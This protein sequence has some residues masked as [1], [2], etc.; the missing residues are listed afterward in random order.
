MASPWTVA[1]P[2]EWGALRRAHDTVIGD[3]AEPVGIRRLVADSW[4]RSLERSLDPDR[5]LARADLSI[6][7][8]NRGELSVEQ[9]GIGDRRQAL[10]ERYQA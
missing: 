8:V 7:Q 5:V 9:H 4:R 6:E 10:I 3:R 1:P 2:D